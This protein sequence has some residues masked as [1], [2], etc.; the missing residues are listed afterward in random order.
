MTLLAPECKVLLSFLI[1]LIDR[2]R[3]NISGE[4][5]K[6]SL[7]WRGGEGLIDGPS[8]Q[9][10]CTGDSRT[11][12]GISPGF[13]S[14]FFEILAYFPYNTTSLQRDSLVTSHAPDLAFDLY[15]YPLEYSTKCFL[16]PCIFQGHEKDNADTERF[17]VHSS[18]LIYWKFHIWIEGKRPS[19]QAS[20]QD[21]KSS[22]R[23]VN[24][25]KINTP[26]PG[27]SIPSQVQSYCDCTSMI[28]KG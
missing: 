20:W 18:S 2:N 13:L 3:G 17:H 27:S 9:R 1:S 22:K 10:Y 12:W 23:D 16:Y 28:A 21:D 7:G 5:S 24:S 15:P 6:M 26:K 11:Q 25:H 8:H 19:L 14:M 4:M